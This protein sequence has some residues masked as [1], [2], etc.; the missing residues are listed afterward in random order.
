MSSQE[1][2]R[3]RRRDFLRGIGLAVGSGLVVPLLQA[4]GG[5]SATPTAAAP[6]AAAAPTV[7]ATQAPGSSGASA[8]QAPA[9]AGGQPVK[10]GTLRYGLDA[11][12]RRMN[13]LNT[14][15]MTDATEHLFD[16]LLTRDP[17]GKYVP[18]LTT[19][20]I[21]D[22]KLTWT[23]HLKPG[24]KFHT[25]D[26]LTADA[27]VW[28]F[29]QAKDP[30]G[31]YGFKGSYASV[32]TATATD[33]NTVVVKMKHPDAALQFILYTVYSSIHN[34]KTYEKLGK[35]DYGVKTVDGTGP[36][37]F[38]EWVPGDHLSIVRNDDYQWGPSFLKNQGPPYLDGIRYHYYADATART[39]A[40]QAGDLDVIVQPNL[41][42]VDRL[43]QS[44]DLSVFTQP[45]PACR[46][47]SFNCEAKP[48][49]D[50]R[51]R[52]AL[53]HAIQ[54]PPIVEKLLFN[55][56]LTASSIVPPTFKD[57]F[58][59]ETKTYFPYDV[60]Q[61]KDLLAA[62]GLTD[63]NGDG[64]VEYEGQAW[65]PE[66]LVTSQSELTQLAQVV[67][68]QAAAIG[69]KIKITQ[70]DAESLSARTRNGDF[71][72]VTGYYLWDGPDTI[73]DWWFD[74]GNIGATNSVRLRDANVDALV[75]K[76]RNAG[77]L[78][79][80]YAAVKD[81]QKVIHGDLVPVIPIY[82]PLDIYVMSK[83]VHGY[84]PNTYSLYPR[85]FDVWLEH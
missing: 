48:W 84:S 58:L 24:V 68:A 14:T 8:T 42:D 12:V 82:H 2:R 37:K 83:K 73:L 17:D 18:R 76:M 85:M 23:F 15:W 43:K 65:E 41:A 38:Q 16:R 56:G 78:E 11:D 20:D 61:G 31:F 3:L 66:M 70:L 32:D 25:G 72:I 9:A 33:P 57:M 59:E 46:V 34:P 30:K 19:W 35:D 10:G 44:P 5:A 26:P 4:C 69:V 77:T 55:Q 60:K 79:D 54:R 49:S 63:K 40:I 74:S 62:A 1:Q 51:V 50:K 67:Q 64:F 22:D 47:V 6:G 13:Q 80:R 45:M 53:A 27:I 52:Q 7:G 36:F 71:A 75:D 81:L 39:T 21:S 29:N 28:W